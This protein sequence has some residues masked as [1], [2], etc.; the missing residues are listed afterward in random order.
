MTAACVSSLHLLHCAVPPVS[1][2]S[3]VLCTH[4]PM[5]REVCRLLDPLL[6]LCLL[7]SYL[8]LGTASLSGFTF[9][10]ESQLVLGVPHPSPWF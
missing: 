1:S 4:C 10:S 2:Y 5:C 7:P 3:S 9:D 6:G 8:S